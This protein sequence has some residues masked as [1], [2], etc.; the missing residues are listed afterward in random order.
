MLA[1]KT[2]AISVCI[3]LSIDSDARINVANVLFEQL[4]NK[5]DL[6]S[7]MTIIISSQQQ[8]QH[9]AF[10]NSCFTLKIHAHLHINHVFLP[11]AT[12]CCTLILTLRPCANAMPMHLFTINRRCL[13]RSRLYLDLN[14][15]WET[16]PRIYDSIYCEIE[17]NVHRIR[18]EPSKR[19]VKNEMNNEH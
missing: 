15:P 17:L 19:G 5:I 1:R 6:F 2:S 10:P 8:Q 13:S 7:F 9:K 11:S 3:Y 18:T 16:H 14:F 4:Y 12:V